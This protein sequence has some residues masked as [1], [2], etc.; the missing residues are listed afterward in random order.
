[1]LIDWFTVGAQALNFIVLVWLLKRFLYKPILDAIDA[2]EKRIAAA[3]A[4]ADS[5]KAEALKEQV[6]YQ[7]K[8]DAFDKQRAEMLRKVSDEAKAER[9]RLSEESRI[10]MDAERAR[11]KESLQ[12]DARKL[13]QSI[14]L[15]AQRE[16]F[17]IARKALND[18]AGETLED[19]IVEVFVGRLHELKGAARDDLAAA[20][21]PGATPTSVRSAF[22]LTAD[23]R[24]AIESA[25]NEV[26]ASEVHLRFDTAP[27]VVSGIELRANGQKVAWSIAD[28]L[29]SLQEGVNTLLSDAAQK[30][31]RKGEKK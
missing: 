15:M 2:R 25:L 31:D 11:Q 26:L 23:Q 3:L 28:Y 24:A 19:R 14:S 30:D 16:V 6:T 21:K 8:N 27:D 4:E 22:D 12:N 9:Q 1:M 29:S 5:K 13:Q 10:A 7:Q 17:S 20:L 18:L